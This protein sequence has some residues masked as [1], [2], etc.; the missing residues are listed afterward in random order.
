V[1]FIDPVL[2]AIGIVAVLVIF[3]PF[4]PM[5]IDLVNLRRE[6][7]LSIYRNRRKWWLVVAAAFGFLLIRTIVG[8]ADPSW[9]IVLALTAAMTAVMFWTGY[10]PFVM[11]P[12][13]GGRVLETAE[14]DTLLQDTDA[15]LGIH[16]NGVA[17]AYSRDA[18]SRPHFFKDS[19]GG[20][21]LVVSYC[22]LCN[23]AVAFDNQFK[24]R[25]LDLSCVTAYNNN[26]IYRDSVTG[27]IIQQLDGAVIEGPDEG[28]ALTQLPVMMT[29]WGQ[30]K[31]MHPDTGLYFAPAGSLRDRLVDAMLQFMIPVNKLAARTRPY[32]R[33]RG[34]LDDRLQAMAFVFGVESNGDR[35]AFPVAEL[36][37]QPVH[38]ETI[39]GEPIVVLYDR[40]LDAGFVYSR[41]VQGRVLTF[42]AAPA[43]GDSVV[44]TDAETGSTWNI[45]GEAIAGPLSGTALA[46]V[47]HYNKA[48]W[49]SWSLFKDGT[50]L[51]A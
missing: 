2:Y 44:A 38:N 50:R 32:H 33:V 9:F 40:A 47:P 30:W 5:T 49:F 1:S 20:A 36:Q 11:T 17:R 7:Q 34:R 41:D 14:A 28:T 3:L 18:I 45:N 43:A 42:E 27:N 19:L 21:E 29:S 6:T 4:S 23:T 10:V 8:S 22:I 48:F 25:A 12:P 15:V 39:G 24:G 26:I 13:T 51:A 37:K 35:L 46:A 16:H 31:A